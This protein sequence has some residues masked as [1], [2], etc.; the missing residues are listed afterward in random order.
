[1]LTEF[2]IRRTYKWYTKDPVYS[3]GH[4]LH[5]TAFNASFASGLPTSFTASGLV[6]NASS[7]KYLDKASFF[8]LPI[9]V[10]NV[11]NVTS[12]YVVLAFAKGEHGPTPYPAKSLVGFSRLHD[13]KPGELATATLGLKLGSIARSDAQGNLVLW[14]GKYS[15]AIDIDSRSDPW[16][17]EITGDQVV[18]EKLAPKT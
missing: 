3:F 16:S 4:G 11:G 2:Y 6:S 7:H 8:S 15:I 1:V 14:P 13:I 18:L 12:D 5:Y 17:F 10:R 9:S